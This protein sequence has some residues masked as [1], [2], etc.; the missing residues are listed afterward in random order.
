MKRK[1][2]D[3]LAQNGRVSLR[4]LKTVHLNYIGQG[5]ATPTQ[6]KLIRFFSN[7]SIDVD[8]LAAELGVSVED[9]KNP[10][11]WSFEQGD[12]SGN[13][14]FDNGEV[15]ADVFFDY[16]TGYRVEYVGKTE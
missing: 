8:Q 13:A 16:N 12:G 7:L 4:S 14:T 2:N 10:D 15:I 3:L 5:G 9:V 6:S 1:V 11:Y